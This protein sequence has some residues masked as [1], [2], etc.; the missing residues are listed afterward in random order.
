[1]SHANSQSVSQSVSQSASKM[2]P[3][4]ALN[5]FTSK[6]RRNSPH[7]KVP[8]STAASAEIQVTFIFAVGSL[9][10][11]MQNEKELIRRASAKGGGKGL[12]CI[13]VESVLT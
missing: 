1:M 13:C 3:C 5:K 7:F 11:Q 10:K 6:E 8:Q 2:N 4:L 9:D 12:F